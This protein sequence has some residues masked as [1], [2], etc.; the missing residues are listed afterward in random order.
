MNLSTLYTLPIV[1]WTHA[2]QLM[3]FFNLSGKFLQNFSGQLNTI[4]L[5]LCELYE[6][7]QVSLGLIALEI[8]HIAV[9]VI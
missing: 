5:I 9:I 8:C 2:H 6:L 4:I 1:S 3:I 7:H